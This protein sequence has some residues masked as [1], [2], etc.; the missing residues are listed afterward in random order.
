MKSLRSRVLNGETLLGCFLNLGSS[1]TAEIVGQSGFDWVLVDLEHGA[2]FE[3]NLLHQLQALEHTSAAAIVRIEAN[4]RQR[5]HRVL[6]LGAH[7][8]MVP[9]V[10][11]PEQA[12][13]AVAALRYP[14]AGIRGVS[15][16]NRAHGFGKQPASYNQYA[17]DHVLGVVQIESEESL[18][19]LDAIAA[20][21]G[22]DVLFVGPGDLSQSL[23][24][25]SEFDHPRF[26]EALCATATAAKIHGKAAGTLLG[27]PEDAAHFCRLGYRFLACSSDGALI[28]RGAQSLISSLRAALPM[29]ADGRPHWH[30]RL[31]SPTVSASK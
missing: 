3:S 29:L 6:D 23:G 22:V 14:P 24:V 10:D 2:G 26:Q 31:T 20:I 11:N 21:D 8:I 30:S 15:K 5:F 18:Q 25:P 27:Q 7:G 4:E 17:N 16:M 28:Y 1:L 9:R 12:R 19:H 13:A